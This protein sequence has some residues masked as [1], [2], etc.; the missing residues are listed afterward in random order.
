MKIIINQNLFF[1]KKLLSLLFVIVTIS[2]SAQGI[3][4]TGANTDGTNSARS[5]SGSYVVFDP[6]VGGDACFITGTNQNFIFRAESFTNDFEYAYTF[7]L[8]FPSGWVV[9]SVSIFGTPQC[10]VGSW[11]SL[12]ATVLDPPNTVQIN[13][14]RYQSTNDHCSAYYMVNV[15]PGPSIGDAS[16]SW[17][18]DGDGYGNAPHHPCSNDG[19]APSGQEACD[20]QVN[21][22][23]V[24][25]ACSVGP[26]IY[27]TPLDQTN[28]ECPGVKLDFKVTL[29][30]QTGASRT[31]TL[32]YAV[33]TGN[34]T[35][36]GPSSL[37]V[38][39]G[40]SKDF[41]VSLT[42][43]P[44]LLEGDIV[45][46]SIEANGGGYSA[47]ASIT[48]SI[49]QGGWLDIATEPN[50]GRMDNVLVTY[51]NLVW[52]IT[53][54][55]AGS[56]VRYYNPSN[57]T[58]TSVAGSTFN[59]NYARSGA[60]YG[61]KAFVYGDAAGSFT[62][63][64]S[65]DMNA[66]VWTNETPSGTPPGLSGIWAP[67]WVADAATGYLYITGGATTPGGGNLTT[68]YVYDPA[69]NAWLAPLPNFT[70]PRDFHAAF[71][72]NNPLTGHRMLA[73][74]GGIN[75]SSVALTST[76]CYDL[77][78]GVWNAENADIPVLPQVRWG[79]GYAHNVIG[80]DHQLWVVGG[81]D[82]SGALIPGSAYYDVSAG[83]WVDGGIYHATPVYRT[84]AIALNGEV[85]KIGGSYGSFNYTGLSSKHFEC[86]YE[87]QVI[88][89]SNWALF[90]GIGLI[91]VFAVVRFRKMV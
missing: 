63:L 76:Q 43:Y 32:D 80:T 78:T 27:L 56:D 22:P 54:Y 49:I 18:W 13:H 17:Y 44:N 33:T 46:A 6:G 37:T 21:P 72:F 67:A 88:P 68:V 24:V 39:D 77:V 60:A 35:V 85:Y 1:M 47:T 11:G 8:K 28:V 23:A 19:Y 74:A 5:L 34:G 52:S 7:W 16:V 82:A 40:A 69:N 51:N 15:T 38:G 25:P 36:S 83:T 30:N 12:N 48:Q 20:E 26:Y 31:F 57:D 79:M 58:W 42:S 71:I 66:N 4:V 84:S 55:G 73:V 14:P 50:N 86:K 65:Y 62:G 53:G 10:D 2:V 89:V 61:S 64:W 29:I 70:S 75:S 3:A 90:I 45:T 41:T 91:L 81:A 59:I 9:N 87:G